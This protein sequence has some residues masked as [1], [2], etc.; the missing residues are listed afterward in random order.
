[1]IPDWEDVERPEHLGKRRDKRFI[2]WNKTYGKDGWRLIWKIG[3]IPVDFLGACT[4]YEDAYFRY[5]LDHPNILSKL[6]RTAYNVY[7]DAESNVESIFDYNHQ[8]TGATHIQDIAIRRC[9]LR[10][11]KTFHG[12]KLICVRQE[13][14]NDPLSTIL[15]PG[16]VPFHRPDL[17]IKPEIKGWWD[18]GT[19]ESFYQSNRVLQKFIWG[20]G[21]C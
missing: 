14:G 11:G 15:S 10:M 1:M 2:E 6:L 9:V 7:D 20:D 13:G 8:E 3:K 17:I 12:E 5:F 18:K 16:R 4:L 19:V 21:G